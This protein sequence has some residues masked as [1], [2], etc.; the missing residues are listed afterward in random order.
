MQKMYY[1]IHFSFVQNAENTKL[2]LRIIGNIFLCK[3]ANLTFMHHI[4]PKMLILTLCTLPNITNKKLTKGVVY[5]KIDTFTAEM[6]ARF[7]C[8]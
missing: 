2:D 3:I 5:D 8:I 7:M 4:Q 6:H 1:F